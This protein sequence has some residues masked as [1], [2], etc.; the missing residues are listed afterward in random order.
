MRPQVC[1]SRA[2]TAYGYTSKAP[3]FRPKETSLFAFEITDQDLATVMARY[4]LKPSQD[5][6]EAVYDRIDASRVAKVA[7]SI[8]FAG[9]E[10]DET[11][12]ER[13]TEAAYDE[14]TAQLVQQG[15][16]PLG[17]VVKTGSES[18][19]QYLRIRGIAVPA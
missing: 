14:V 2:S 6:L 13:Q 3:T 1:R 18:L 4:G 5:E 7:L 9:T 16:V 10:D 15:L 17:T 11:I 8:D 19:L 12:L